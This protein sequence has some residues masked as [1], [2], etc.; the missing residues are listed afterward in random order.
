MLI[1]K[2]EKTFVQKFYRCTIK[3][4]KHELAACRTQGKNRKNSKKI[5]LNERYNRK[6]KR[7]INT[8][9]TQ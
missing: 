1:P 9:K 3:K 4:K 2:V 7:T 5:I 6:V 8:T